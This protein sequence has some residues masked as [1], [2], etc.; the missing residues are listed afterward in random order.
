M[1]QEIMIN[2][3]EYWSFLGGT[4]GKEPACQM[5]LTREAGLTLGWENLLE[6]GMAT[7]SSILTLP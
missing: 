2:H 6:E 1:L 7:H 4:S 5:Q 3:F